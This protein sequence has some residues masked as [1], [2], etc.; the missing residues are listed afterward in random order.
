MSYNLD[1]LE[2]NVKL[3]STCIITFLF[4]LFLNI[5]YLYFFSVYYVLPFLLFL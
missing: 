1:E 4:V 2:K 5:L 3:D